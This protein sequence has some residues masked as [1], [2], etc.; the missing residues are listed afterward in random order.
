M[1][2][3]GDDG[4]RYARWVESRPGFG[5][6]RISIYPISSQA[7]PKLSLRYK[8]Q[9]VQ[10]EGGTRHLPITDPSR[11]GI[12]LSPERWHA[13]L[14][15]DADND[16]DAAPV[17]LDVRNGYEWDVGHF[18]GAKRPVQESFRETVETNVDAT[19]GGPLAGVRKARSVHWFP[20]DPVGV[21]NADP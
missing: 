1:S 17:L 13:M 16:P 21:V 15:N 6:M 19:G 14:E 7:H 11:R 4:E 3:R 20:Y 18:R 12:P 10:L 5:G 8:P 9:L 2:G